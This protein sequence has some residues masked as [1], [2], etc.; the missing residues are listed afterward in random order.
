MR[1]RPFHFAVIAIIVAGAVLSAVRA[2]TFLHPLPLRPL[3][4]C[5][6]QVPFTSSIIFAQIEGRFRDQGLDVLIE[7]VPSG[8]MAV[9]RLMAGDCDL[10][11]CRETPI[12]LAVMRQKPIRILASIAIVEESREILARQDRGLFTLADLVGKQVG[13]V[14]ETSSDY[15]L[16]SALDYNG[17]SLGSIRRIDGEPQDLVRAMEEGRLDAICIWS[18]LSDRLLAALEGKLVQLNTE[19]MTRAYWN[20]VASDQVDQDLVRSALS[21]IREAGLAI[22]ADPAA[23]AQLC[24][25]AMDISAADLEHGWKEGDFT[26][27]L[28]QGLILALER[29]ARWAV[30][31]GYVPERPIPN[32][33]EVITP[34]PLVGV[35]PQA[36]TMVHPAMKR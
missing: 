11:V 33:L 24:S 22:E 10:I 35:D 7:T 12:A 3:R 28:D 8:R 21:A 15:A 23:A 4:I 18:P 27:Q 1:M 34:L 30:L 29:D 36:V 32:F 2:W 17:I 26:V 6:P 31:K 16:D 20:L 5:M 19:V 13:C 9:D 25:K 14:R